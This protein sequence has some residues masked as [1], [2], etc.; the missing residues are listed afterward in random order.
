M[1]RP[2]PKQPMRL[3]FRVIA[4]FALCAGTLGLGA[5]DKKPPLPPTP[6]VSAS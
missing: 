6:L 3:I 5:C 4:L 2:L 1:H